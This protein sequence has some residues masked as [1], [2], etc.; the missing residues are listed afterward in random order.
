MQAVLWQTR[1]SSLLEVFRAA[2]G[3]GSASSIGQWSASSSFSRAWPL[4][5]ARLTAVEAAML[6]DFQ[7][8]GAQ[9]EDRLKCLA[10]EGSDT[11]FFSHSGS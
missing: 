6:Q 8:W 10:M 11:T 1:A 7:W 4:A 2:C 9:M 5:V 3:Q